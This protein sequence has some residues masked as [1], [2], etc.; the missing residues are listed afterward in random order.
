MPQVRILSLGPYLHGNFDRIAV[1]VF[2]CKALDIKGFEHFT[3]IKRV[4][5]SYRKGHP[6]FFALVL[7]PTNRSS[8]ELIVHAMRAI[9]HFSG[10]IVQSALPHNLNYR[11]CLKMT[12]K[13][14]LKQSGVIRLRILAVLREGNNLSARCD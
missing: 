12:T 9:V 3:S 6:L 4:A 7:P 8:A 10:V 11:R 14:S 2:F 13:S 5:N 1:E